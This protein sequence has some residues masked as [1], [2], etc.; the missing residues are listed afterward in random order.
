MIEDAGLFAN[1]YHLRDF[2]SK[3]S[4]SWDTTGGNADWVMIQPGETYT[5]LDEKGSGCVKHI[6]WTYIENN[7]TRRLNIL[8]G[9]VLRIFWDLADIPS[10][11]VPL[12][13]FFGVTNGQLRPIRSLAFVTNPGFSPDGHTT[14]G[15]NCYLPMPFATG[16]RIEIENQSSTEGRIWYHVDY[17]LYNNAAVLPDGTGR[18][19]ACW[20]RENPTQAVAV[21]KGQDEI[22]NLSGDENYVILDTEANGQ[23]VGYFLTVVNNER[24]WYGEGDDMVFIDGEGFPPSIHGTG[25][26]EIFGGG[27]CPMEEYSGPYTGFHCIENRGRYSYWGTNG[28]YRFYLVDPLRFRKSIRVTLEHGHGNDKANDYS[29]VAFWYQ[30]G[31]NSHLP[32]LPP[33][34]A[35]RVNFQ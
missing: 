2:Y 13:D 18:L 19:H 21:P 34:A 24:E 4:S 12:G 22:K 1:I 8:R 6:Y 26:E 14:W 23:F 20:I 7:E 17:E 32:S 29:S 25:T 11:E 9:M 30:C 28:M 5:L 10:V 35:R 33:F 15:F 3:R 31:V 16:T 27:A